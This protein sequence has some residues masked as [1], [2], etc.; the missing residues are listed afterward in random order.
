[1]QYRETARWDTRKRAE[2]QVLGLR[3]K[4]RG[5]QAEAVCTEMVAG[6]FLELKPDYSK[7]QE[8]N[9]ISSQMKRNTF[10]HIVVQLRP[11]KGDFQNRRRERTD[12]HLGD[13]MVS[14]F[15]ARRVESV[16]SMERKH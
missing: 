14:D 8:A 7:T 10:R 12:Y 9:G 13:K 3:T 2:E 15:P 5:N 4:I 11:S 16:K 1:M 6:E